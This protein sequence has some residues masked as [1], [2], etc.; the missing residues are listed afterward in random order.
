[1]SVSPFLV[2]AGLVGIAVGILALA[3]PGIT[4]G[5]LISVFG[6]YA[7]LDGLSKLLHGLTESSL[8]GPS[9][10]TV[11]QGFVG[12]AIGMVAALWPG[13][14]ALMLVTF[15]GAWA[16]AMGVFDVIEAVRLRHYVTGDWL[17]GLSGVVSLLFGLFLFAFPVGGV[18]GLAWLLGIYA[19]AT[20]VARIVLGTG[21]QSSVTA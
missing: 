14:T 20:G 19:M 3:W 4:L 7:I 5:L 18:V 12:V 16:I 11:V 21:I 17:L 1:M 15:V 10:A 13:V 9:W 6:T 8:H 2:I